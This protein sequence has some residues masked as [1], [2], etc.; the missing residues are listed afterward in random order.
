MKFTQSIYADLSEL[1][2]S[3]SF[4]TESLNKCSCKPAEITRSTLL[5]EE[6]LV[7]LIKKAEPKQ[8]ISLIVIKWLG[9]TKI[10][11]HSKGD[12]FSASEFSDDQTDLREAYLHPDA[13]DL[14]R[15][16]IIKAFHDK[17]SFSYHNEKNCIRVIVG[18]SSQ[19]NLFYALC[20]LGAA[21]IA[22]I[23]MRLFLSPEITSNINE[24]LFD[25]IK[26]MFLNALK[27]IMGP[28]IFFSIASSISTFSDL[29]KLGRIGAKVMSFYIFTTT[30]AISLGFLLYYTFS[31]GQFGE[32]SSLAL[33]ETLQAPDSVNFK[34]TILG[35]IPS[36]LIQPFATANTLQIIFLSVLTGIAAGTLNSK[37]EAVSNFLAQANT[38]F[39]K[40][41]SIITHFLPFMVFASIVSMVLTMQFET[42][43][44]LLSLVATILVADICMMAAYILLV[45]VFTK[46]GPIRFMRSVFST[47]LNALAL[48]SSSAA[49]PHTMEV[50]NKKLRISPRL[51]S[52]SIPLGA[53]INMDGLSLMLSLT[54][55][56]F[57]N[58]F[59]ITITPADLLSL[60]ITIIILSIG[61]PGIPGAGILC[62]TILFKQ[63]GIP[64]EAL[65]IFIGVYSLLDPIN[66][67]NNV[68]GDVT[69]SYVVAKRNGLMQQESKSP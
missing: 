50:C 23:P 5:I 38:L 2:K 61:T 14:I 28:L 12:E 32:F 65:S 66:S 15:G 33:S 49:M 60:I 1:P 37:S 68:F 42:A 58:A 7:S 64:I 4:I 40:V 30:I 11:L 46:T 26:T 69:G 10:Y 54:T 57:A 39:M 52:F 27:M 31:P 62:L 45:K 56:F 44:T 17:L 47:W 3:I 21:I 16:M 9:T 36:N 25:P 48:A 59:G 29:R 6:L 41:A 34:D 22:S 55:L 51:Y 24:F 18:E 35:I 13:E 20:A 8:K 53:T 19:K 67:A 43:K 63:Y